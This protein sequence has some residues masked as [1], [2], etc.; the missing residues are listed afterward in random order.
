MS[1]M[2]Y[3]AYSGI[4]AAVLFSS[5]VFAQG[6]I[7]LRIGH[8]PGWDPR[9]REGRCELRVW[10][11]HHAELR[12]RGDGISVR[13]LEGARSYDE[14]SSCS[15][16]LP[17]D[18]VRDFQVHQMAGRN[19]VNLVQPPSRMNNYTAL[20]AINDDQGG[21]DH[22]AFELTWGS[23]GDRP[24][25]AAPFFDDVRACQDSV[26]QRFLSRNR[27]DSYIDF[28]GSADR[29]NQAQG[30]EILRGHGAARSRSESRDLTYSCVIDARSGQV[31]SAD[32]QYSGA[33]LRANDRNP[34]R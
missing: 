31:R 20:F 10:V 34:L 24:N 3:P 26:R 15:Q 12:I 33:G 14:G 29:Q 5:V 4:A 27:R 22:Y 19:P 8:Q 11:D 21:G 28:E 32:Y 23:A 18:S 30:R 13:T 1:T 7:Q 25:A 2:K 16:P 6:D 17:Y 9:A